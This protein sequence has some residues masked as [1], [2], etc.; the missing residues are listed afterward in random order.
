MDAEQALYDRTLP[1]LRRA[2]SFT[3]AQL[4]KVLGAS[5]AQV[6]RI[7]NQA[8][9]YLSTLAG[10]VAAFGGELQLRAVFDA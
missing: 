4:A 1:E 6:S 8:D 9:L 7:E 10:Y 3:Q 5:Q 2:R